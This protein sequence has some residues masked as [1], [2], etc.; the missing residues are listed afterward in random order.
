MGLDDARRHELRLLAA[1]RPAFP[2]L[3]TLGRFAR[4]IRR[5]PGLGWLVG[6]PVT[7]HR[8]L[9]DADHFTTIG[10]GIVGHLWAQVL[11]D[12]VHEMLDGP[13][14]HALR[15]RARDLFSEDRAAAL[16]SRAAGPRLRRCTAELVAG[17]AVDVADLAREVGGRIVA[18]LLGLNVGAEGA[19]SGEPDDDAAYREVFDTGEQLA[20]LA[21]R[22]TRSTRMPAGTVAAAR[23]IVARM[24]GG[25]AAAWRDAPGDTLLGRCR[26]LGLGLRETEGLATLLMV[27]GTQTTASAMARTVALL[28]D[29]GEQERLRAEPQRMVEAVR[30]GLRVTSPVPV[31]GRSV[32]A[33]LEVAGRRLRAGQR[34]LLLTWTANNASGGFDLDR[35]YLPDNRQLWFGAGRHFCLGAAVGRAELTS[36]LNALLAAGRPWRVVARRYRRGALIPTYARLRIAL[37]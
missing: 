11:G 24:T 13:G 34:V 14:H 35:E 20:A 10:E 22:S 7:M 19:G 27:A 32:S 15:M 18:D 16:V 33:D 12:W 30:E 28:H 5:V 6:D 31:I 26:E 8:I 9:N 37:A 1:S 23:T 29:T 2:V 17:G 3:L 25:V 4:P 36:L 21:L